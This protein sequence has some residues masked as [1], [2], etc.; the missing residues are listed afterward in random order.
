MHTTVYRIGGCHL[1]E[2]HGH[3]FIE[4]IE[5]TIPQAA[6][7]DTFVRVFADGTMDLRGVKDSAFGYKATLDEWV[8][9]L[10]LLHEQQQSEGHGL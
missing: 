4:S 1:P 6:S 3:P 2:C 8:Q 10:R 7:R 9:G 5:V